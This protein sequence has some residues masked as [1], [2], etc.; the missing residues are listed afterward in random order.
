MSSITLKPN[1]S[2]LGVIRMVRQRDRPEGPLPSFAGQTVVI[3]GG[4]TGYGLA[5]AKLLPTLGTERLIL[6]V[7]SVERGETAVEP[8]R[9]SYP[10]FKI[11]V[12]ELDMLSYQSVQAFA[13]RCGSLSRVD[14][15]ILNAG[16]GKIESPSTGHEETMQVNYLSTALLSILLL[17]I[18]KP[19]NPSSPPGRL[20]IVGSSKG[21]SAAFTE[22]KSKPLIKEFDKEWKGIQAGD[23]RYSV[24]KTLVAI[25]VHKLSQIVAPSDVIINN[26]CPGFSAN[27]ALSREAKG[28]IFGL[29]IGLM[30]AFM[31]RTPE[32]GAWTYIDAVAVKGKESHGSFIFGWQIFPFH[33][34]MY[35]EEGKEIMERLWNE[36]VTEQQPF[37]VR[38]ALGAMQG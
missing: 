29:M 7:R 10:G 34:V 32:Q 36:T 26:F 22:R 4:A 23:E 5:C 25:F 19:K 21:Y 27:T 33:P 37:G 14:A 30:Q 15:A 8:I 38:E 12:W 17:P 3:T 31:G 9:K 1:I 16:V 35:T 18:L 24:S 20:T 28:P 11:E 2:R 6:G 13:Q